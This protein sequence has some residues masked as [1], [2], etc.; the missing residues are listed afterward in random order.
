MQERDRIELEE[1]RRALAAALE[2]PRG[3]ARTM[4]AGYYTSPEF[5][6][7]E[8]EELFRRQ[9]V[10]LGHVGEIPKPGDYFATELIGE[11]IIVVRD[12]AGAVRVLS[13]VCRHRGSAILKGAG[14][15]RRFTCGYHGWT[16][17]L[18][19]GLLAAPLMESV[20]SFDKST[21]RLPEFRTEVW[22]G[23]LFVNLQGGAAPLVQSLESTTSFIRNYHPAERHFLFGAEETWATNWKCLVENF[24]EGY[25]LSPTHSK[26]LHPVTPTTLC[27]KLPDGETFTGYRANFNPGY[28]ERGP[29]HPDLEPHERRS[30]VFYCVFPSFVVG[31]CPDF[32]LYMCLRPLAA[33]RVGIRWGIVGLTRDPEAAI[34]KDYIRLCREFCAEDEAAL[35]R[36]QRGLKT[37]YYTPGPLAPDDF[38]GT[39][40]DLTRYVA[41]RITGGASA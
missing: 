35:E 34:V 7:I 18:D 28:P 3:L 1:I 25:H 4:P 33:D 40:W 19:G 39:I 24:M 31:F 17:R 6:A 41:R 10:C 20:A 13:N 8:K 36:L 11:Q 37:R 32:T 16:Y 22:H 12:D 14:N 26:T 27:R 30:D 9:W 23:F 5:L 21:C 15:A 38:E 29:Y 2:M